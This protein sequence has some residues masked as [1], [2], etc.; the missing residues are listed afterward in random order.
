MA[1]VGETD[2]AI[3]LADEAAT[4]R[5]AEDLALILLPGDVIALHGD[6]GMGKSTLARALLR[7]FADDAHL[8]VPS[9]TFT[10]VQTYDFP[11]LTIAHFDLYR[12]GGAEELDEIGFDEA[13]RDGAALIEWPSGLRMP[14]RAIACIC[15]LRLGLI[16][17]PV[18]PGSKLRLVSWPGSID[19]WRSGRSLKRMVGARARGAT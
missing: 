14:C 4:V 18:S 10:L 2:R 12:L 15:I 13:I 17:M 8:E 1:E 11:R 7:A 3:V 5:L 6:L 16:S 9:P 19:R